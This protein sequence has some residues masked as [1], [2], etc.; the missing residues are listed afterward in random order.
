MTSF[1]DQLVQDFGAPAISHSGYFLLVDGNGHI[2][3]AYDSND[4]PR[5]D[6]MIHDARYLARTVH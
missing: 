4:V 6:E 2:R 3:G 1:L 5:L